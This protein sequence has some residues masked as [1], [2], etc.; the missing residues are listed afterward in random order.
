MRMPALIVTVALSKLASV[1]RST[2][3]TVIPMLTTTAASCSEYA[4]LL[5]STSASTGA[6]FTGCTDTVRD[7]TDELKL[8]S[9]IP[10]ETTRSAAC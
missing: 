4:T 3:D 9:L 2:S 1:I 5:V 7:T 10:H 6:S 8:P